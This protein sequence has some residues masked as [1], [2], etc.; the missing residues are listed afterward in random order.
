MNGISK[1]YFVFLVTLLAVLLFT[2]CLGS[3]KN[4]SHDTNIEIVKPEEQYLE[5]SIRD[6]KT[7]GI[8]DTTLS[9]ISG[10]IGHC[11]IFKS[12]VVLDT[13]QAN[14]IE[15]KSIE[16]HH[17]YRCFSDKKGIYHLYFPAGYYNITVTYLGFN[18][19][20][21]ENVNVI[22]GEIKRLDVQLAYAGLTPKTKVFLVS[23]DGELVEIPKVQ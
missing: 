17:V 19:I 20:V 11:Y 4:R 10:T 18:T 12:K 7:I 23:A 15:L 14:R 16:T 1:Y 9:F 22:S 2:G 21:L 8:A 5:S 6:F 3:K 13:V